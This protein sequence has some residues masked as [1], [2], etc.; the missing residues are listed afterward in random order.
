MSDELARR[1]RERQ[2]KERAAASAAEVKRK[3]AE[4]IALA[5]PDQ[6]S[7][8]TSDLHA[9]VTEANNKFATNGEP[10]RHFRWQPQ[11]QPETGNIARTLIFHNDTGVVGSISQ[12][13]VL[14]SLDGKVTVTHPSFNRTFAMSGLGRQEWD[15]LLA[16][17]YSHDEPT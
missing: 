8:A 7:K 5:L 12:T 3:R 1:I 15:M 9:A 17:I 13:V 6:W 11:P 16:D 14:V 4:E 2:E 10:R